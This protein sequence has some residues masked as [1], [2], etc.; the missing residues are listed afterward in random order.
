MAV[1]RATSLLGD[2]EA[3][4]DVAH[5]VFVDLL[6]RPEQFEGRSAFSTFLYAAVTHRCLQRLRDGRNR[7]RI[8][9]LQGVDPQGAIAPAALSGDVD[10]LVL[11][12]QLVARLPPDLGEVA[13]YFYVDS[14]TYDQIAETLGC[15][16]RHIADLLTRFRDAAAQLVRETAS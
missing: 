14:M 3:G 6:A 16:R 11:L 8:L 15:S 13:V 7:T 4:N 10:R 2:V 5:E 12:R 1:R 9:D